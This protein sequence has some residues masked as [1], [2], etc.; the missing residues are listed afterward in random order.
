MNRKVRINLLPPELAGKAGKARATRQAAGAA[1]PGA[2]PIFVLIAILAFGAACYGCYGFYA[3]FKAEKDRFESTKTELEAT[4]QKVKE[5]R[6][7]FQEFIETRDLILALTRRQ[8]LAAHRR[9]LPALKGE[10]DS[11]D[12]WAMI[13]M[14]AFPFRPAPCWVTFR[15]A[16]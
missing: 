12:P 2:N 16:P 7:K 11:T 8:V 10:F 5:T 6:A 1:P 15:R 3:K 4:E 13:Q 9:G 14:E